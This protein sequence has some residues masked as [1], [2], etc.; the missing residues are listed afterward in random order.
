MPTPAP[1]IPLDA[2]PEFEPIFG[3]IV[4]KVDEA[5][6]RKYG[7]LYLPQR[8]RERTVIGRIHAVYPAATDGNEEI[9][10]Q[11]SVGDT[12]IFGQYTGT[13]IT[14]NRELYIICKEHDLL[15]IVRFP[16]GQLPDI[17]E[18]L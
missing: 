2:E 12:V 14:I 13:S 1:M 10:P 5:P 7:Q 16:D 18:V 9:H 11:V 8:D 15:S 17:E 4:I 6:E 3:K